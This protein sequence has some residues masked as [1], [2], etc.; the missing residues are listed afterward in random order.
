MKSNTIKEGI[1]NLVDFPK[2]VLLNLP[3]ITVIGNT[4][5]TVENHRGIIE[6]IPERIRINSTIGMIRISGKNMIINSVMTEI[7]VITGKILSIEI[8]V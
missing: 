5:I 2:E 1:L 7:L 6:Y 3:K 8:I 4:Q